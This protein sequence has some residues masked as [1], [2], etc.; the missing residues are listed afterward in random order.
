MMG[1]P[2]KN[3]VRIRNPFFNYYK[4]MIQLRQKYPAL[5]R[6]QY[7]PADNDN[8]KVFSFY[9][10]FGK[11]KVLVIVN[12]S[13]LAQS[14]TFSIPHYNSKILFGQSKL[15]KN[16]IELKPYEVVVAAVQ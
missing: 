1:F 8:N 9:R 16:K 15:S 13:D 7:A 4:S 10:V 3:S 14:A 12:L 11:K 5:A 2:L 6:G